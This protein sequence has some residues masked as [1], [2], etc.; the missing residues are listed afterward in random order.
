[1]VNPAFRP[2]KAGE[3]FLMHIRPNE[4]FV[5]TNDEEVV[6]YAA[7]ATAVNGDW[8]MSADMT[9]AA[10]RVLI[11][12]NRGAAT[13]TAPAAAPANYVE[14]PFTAKGG[15]YYRIFMRAFAQDDS[16]D[17]DSVWIQ[18]SDSVDSSGAPMW[19][20][21][22]TSGTA[23]VLEDCSGCGV[24]GWGWQ[25]NGFGSGVFGPVVRFAS[26]GRHTI[27]V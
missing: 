15:V 19:R 18:F 22:S 3:G 2:G 13:V 17:N 14:I 8:Q 23:I 12:P 11:N 1:A 24:H 9:A 26:T 16:T 7:D 6:L 5:T 27:R 10:A 21:G 4:K 20:I 25:D